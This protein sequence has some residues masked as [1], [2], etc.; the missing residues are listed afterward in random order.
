MLRLFD[1]LPWISPLLLLQL[2]HL[3]HN[4]D[5]PCTTS[6]FAAVHG[7]HKYAHKQKRAWL[8]PWK[9]YCTPAAAHCATGSMHYPTAARCCMSHEVTACHV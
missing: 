5:V 4:A 7:T 1:T 8:D 6:L 9:E 3:V 2:L